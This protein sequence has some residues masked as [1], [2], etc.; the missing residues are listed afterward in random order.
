MILLLP[1][2]MILVTLG[3]KNTPSAASQNP[4]ILVLT[5]CATLSWSCPSLGL[6]FLQFVKPGDGGEVL[7]STSSFQ[8]T[9]AL[10]VVG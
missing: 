9:E 10:A 3:Y 7:S 6:F 8:T 4:V 1:R 5:C 2:T